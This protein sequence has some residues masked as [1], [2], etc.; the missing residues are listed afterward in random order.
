MSA[1]SRIDFADKTRCLE[2][3]CAAS[4]ALLFSLQEH[5]RAARGRNDIGDRC[6][7]SRFTE[8]SFISFLA[9]PS[10]KC[11]KGL[12]SLPSQHFPNATVVEQPTVNTSRVNADEKGCRACAV[13][14]AASRARSADP[15]ARTRDTAMPRDFY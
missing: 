7:R 11:R 12:F 4:N 1:D 14:I 9:G 15:L 5:G 2:H 13:A 3:A 10:E 8:P 6:H